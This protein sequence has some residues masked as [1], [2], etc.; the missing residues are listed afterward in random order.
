MDALEDLYDKVAARYAQTIYYLLVYKKTTLPQD[1]FFGLHEQ[2]ALCE[3]AIVELDEIP[4]DVD[5]VQARL[6]AYFDERITVLSEELLKKEKVMLRVRG[7]PDD[8][9]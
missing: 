4:H 7:V 8:C 1:S 2:I 3:Q 6:I 9:S 5:E